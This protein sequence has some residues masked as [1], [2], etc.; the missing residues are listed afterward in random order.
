MKEGTQIMKNMDNPKL[1]FFC[2]YAEHHNLLY[3]P[4]ILSCL[5]VFKQNK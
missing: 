4:P 5:Y 2:T 3:P 1:H